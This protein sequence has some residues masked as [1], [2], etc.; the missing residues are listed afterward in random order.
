MVYQIKVSLEDTR[1]PVWRRL[2]IQ[3]RISFLDLHFIIQGAMGWEN[4]HM[5]NFMVNGG[6]LNRTIGVSYDDDWGMDDMEDAAEVPVNSVLLKAKDKVGYVYDFGDN[7][8]HT[9]V[10]EKVLNEAI[11][12]KAI[13]VK[14]TGACPPEDCGSI[15]G[16]YQ[17]VESVNNPSAPDHADMME[18]LGLSDG[19]TWDPKV[20]DVDEANSQIQDYLNDPYYF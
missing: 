8:Y 18:W 4:A 13:C 11:L 1:P 20:F 15:P 5:F 17:L 14:G 10:L 12:P 6:G 9:V 19:E 2:I 7:W 3:P 16:Y